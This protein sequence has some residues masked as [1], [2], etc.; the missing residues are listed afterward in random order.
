MY[1]LGNIDKAGFINRFIQRR[2]NKISN[3]E[4]K[5]Y[6]WSNSYKP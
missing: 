6:G 5:G 3:K 2:N 4:Q 1:T